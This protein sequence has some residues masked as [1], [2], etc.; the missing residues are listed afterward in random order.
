[1]IHFTIHHNSGA[2]RS[3]EAIPED[4]IDKPVDGIEMMLP[5]GG[6]VSFEQMPDRTVYSMGKVAAWCANL[7]ARAGY[8]YYE[9]GAERDRLVRAYLAAFGNGWVHRL[10]SLENSLQFAGIKSAGHFASDLDFILHLTEQAG[11]AWLF[12][13]VDWNEE[14]IGTFLKNYRTA[15]GYYFKA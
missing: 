4:I 6:V 8:L 15:E 11:E 5:N 10:I 14:A 9:M 13:V 1:M 7:N 2:I 3:V 12:D